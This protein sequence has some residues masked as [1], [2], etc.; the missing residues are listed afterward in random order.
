MQDQAVARLERLD[1]KLTITLRDHVHKAL[2]LAIL[3]GRYT[4]QERLNERQLAEELGVSTTPLKE[5]L[6]QL[7]SE[8]LI[9]TLPRRGVIVL[10]SRTWAEE[11]ILARAALE[12]M[13]AHL[14]A[15]RIDDAGRRSLQETIAAMAEASGETDPDRLLAL[16]EQ[17]HDQ[18]HRASE[19]QYLGKLIERQRFYDAGT[20]RI[21]HSDPEEKAR[22]LAEHR[23][24]CGAIVDRDIEGA[25]RAM[26]DHV[27]RSG[28]H[29]L[30]L[31]FRNSDRPGSAL[32]AVAE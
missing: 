19:C 13:I 5:A 2:R 9:A 1:P 18:I 17:F 25:E 3:S 4:P 32:H 11:M 12:S 20:R 27:V 6:R 22:A 28:D 21:I 14:A 15:R 8:G 10:Y 7:E 30:R 24:I 23:A 29:Y 26:R 16:N 31:V